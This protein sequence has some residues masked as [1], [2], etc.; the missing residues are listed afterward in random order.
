PL[1]RTALLR[2]GNKEHALLL[3]MHHIVSD[4]WSMGLLFQ[5]LTALY[6]RSPLPELPI[7]Y[8]DFAVWQRGRLAG[9]ALE[10][11][12]AWWRERLAGAPALLELPTDRP[13]PAAQSFRGGKVEIALSGS[14]EIAAL[15]RRSG[16]TLFMT[17][18]A[19]FDALLSRLTGQLDVVVGSPVAG[20]DRTELEGLIGFFVNTLVLRTDLSGDPGFAGI[21]ERVRQATIGAYTHQELPFEKVVGELAPVR[22]LAHAPLFQVMLTL[23]NLPRRELRLGGA[24]ADLM[25]AEGRTAKFDLTL[26]LAERG[27]RLAGAFQYNSDLFDASTVAR[28]ADHLRT[29][30]EG[31][32]ADPSARLSD[33]P[34]LSAAGRAQLLREWNDTAASIAGIAGIGAFRSLPERIAEQAARTPEAVAVIFGGRSLT[35]AELDR[36]AN[37]L[38]WHLR[39]LGVGPEVRVAISMER[40]PDLLVALLGVL[41]AG[42]AYVPIDPSYPEERRAWMLA[43]S[44]AAVVLD[45]SLTEGEA[46]APPPLDLAPG[47]L[48]YV[49]YT[50]GSTGRPK[51]VQVHHGALVNLLASIRREPGL[52]ATDTMLAV[53]T[54]SFDIAATELFLPLLVGARVVLAGREDAR[55]GARLA[56]LAESSGA[57]VLQ[58][59]PAG[60]QVLL[61]SGWRGNGRL[62]ALTAGEALPR[63]LAERLLRGT[64]AL[65][66]LYGPTEATVYCTAERVGSGGGRITIGRPIASYRVHVLDP[67][68]GL[69]PVGV[70]GEIAV[71][72]EGLARGYAGRSDLT[73]ERFVPDSY[74]RGERLYRTGDLGRLLP[75]GRLDVLGR[76]DHQV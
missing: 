5:E 33:L 39:S 31:A 70:I 2:L 38:A 45:G 40:S 37:R 57:T 13:R 67:D 74:G 26:S 22:T 48:A 75:D 59:T 3:C 1:L 76:I 30:V 64:S 42:G 49:L 14:A 36:R 27:G 41:K 58:A 51:G 65:W 68:L 7:Q 50:S 19:A 73:A 6:E 11:E 66:N 29:L 24:R 54:L 16:A 9:E 56:A 69:A 28:F 23:Q 20:R 61:E 17:L 4:G 52:D 72:G 63:D 18:L 35:Y 43:D 34:L 62:R 25:S 46:E 32:V 15:S 47:N 44:G 53:T 10:Q 8:T 21:L 60:W 55:D 71:G 12:L